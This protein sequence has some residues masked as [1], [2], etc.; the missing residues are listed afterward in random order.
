MKLPLSSSMM[1]L[2]AARVGSRFKAHHDIV[3]SKSAVID[4]Y[5]H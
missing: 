5:I 3:I 1:S 4:N 2:S